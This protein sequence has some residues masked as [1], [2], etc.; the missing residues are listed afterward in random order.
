MASSSVRPHHPIGSSSVLCHSGSALVCHQPSTA[1]RLHSSGYASSVRLCQAPS[2]PRL[3]LSPLSFRLCQAPSSPRLLLSPLS[4][5]LHLGLSSTIHR[6]GTPLFRLRLVP[7]TLSGSFIPSAPPQSSV[8]PA[9]P[10]SVV[11]HPPPWDSTPPATPRPSGSVRLLHPL[12]FSSVICRSS[13]ALVCRRP[14]T[15]SGLHSSGS[16]WSLQLCQAPPSLRLQLD[17]RGSTTVF[18]IPASA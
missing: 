4:F 1:L 10:W 16:A 7:P 15:A 9:P 3:L 11:D 13:S 17:P 8:I 18:R 6:L 5:R 12:G 14:S 2:S